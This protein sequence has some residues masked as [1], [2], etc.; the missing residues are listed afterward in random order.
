MKATGLIV[1]VVVVAAAG[2]AAWWAIHA[3]SGEPPAPPRTTDEHPFASKGPDKPPKIETV[4]ELIAQ[5]A[6]AETR[7]HAQLR[8]Q[9]IGAAALPGLAK[10]LPTAEGP[11][12]N[13]IVSLLCDG[14]DK[15][16]LPPIL[17]LFDRTDEESQ[18]LALKGISHLDATE[19]KERV[20]HIVADSVAP[21]KMRVLAAEILAK[22]KSPEVVPV[23]LSW[24]PPPNETAA[25]RN[26]LDREH[27][28]Y[29]TK[30]I[31]LLGEMQSQD[32][33]EPLR[34]IVLGHDTSL[35]SDAAEALAK[36][37]GQGID[38]IEA[39]L[40][41]KDPERTY[42]MIRALGRSTDPRAQDL[43]RPY[44][45]DSNESIRKAANDSMKLLG[46]KQG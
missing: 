14:K 35:Q 21:T 39:A 33:I 4:D 29:R 20:L 16:Y 46:R 32:A 31:E 6:S 43:I 25:Q 30:A 27:R 17:A 45:A 7:G 1:V 13:L 22:W 19:E 37:G 24:L 9:D 2:G 5:L 36:I 23:L 42:K 40:A 41:L 11:T 15:T 3:S 12:R 34:T 44:L 26:A 18:V 8:L 10:A 28:S 38:A